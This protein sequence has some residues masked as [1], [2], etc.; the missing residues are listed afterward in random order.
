[1]KMGSLPEPGAGRL[2]V[3]HKAVGAL[4]SALPVRSAKVHYSQ[5][6][7]E[8]SAHNPGEKPLC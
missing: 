7:R 8:T 5:H 4:L 3:P 2:F 6:V 1:M